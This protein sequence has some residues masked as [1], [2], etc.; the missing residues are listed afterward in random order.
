VFQTPVQSDALARAL[1]FDAADLDANRQGYMSKRQ[2]TRLRRWGCLNVAFLT[3]A[4]VFVTMG[5]LIFIVFLVP[6]VNPSLFNFWILVPL[7]WVVAGLLYLWYAIRTWR[8]VNADLYKGAVAIGEGRVFLDIAMIQIRTQ[9][10]SSSPYHVK[11][12][13]AKFRVNRRILLA[14]K[15]DEPYCVYYAHHT[16]QILSAE[17]L[18]DRKPLEAEYMEA[19]NE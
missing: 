10:W 4:A 12:A 7:G 1:H 18:P 13:D 19:Q 15:N 11:V 17:W 5:A 9:F 2:R 14:F 16:R 3:I 8:R 6:R